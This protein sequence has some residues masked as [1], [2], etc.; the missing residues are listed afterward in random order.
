M[1]CC[2]KTLLLKLDRFYE[3]MSRSSLEENV[4][5]PRKPT[6]ISSSVCLWYKL[7]QHVVSVITCN[8]CFYMPAN[9]TP[10]KQE[11]RR[12]ISTK[13]SRKRGAQAMYT[14]GSEVWISEYTVSRLIHH[15]CCNDSIFHW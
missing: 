3:K 1:V 10:H 11:H 12:H 8:I 5:F 6:I 9:I 13:L 2:L 4:L 15:D 7:S 14:K